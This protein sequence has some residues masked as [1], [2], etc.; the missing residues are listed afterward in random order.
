[1]LLLFTFSITSKRFLHDLVADHKDTIACHDN[2]TAHHIHSAGFYCTCDDL[3]AES[4]YMSGD[5][6]IELSVPAMFIEKQPAFVGN[7]HYVAALF[8][9]LRGPPAVI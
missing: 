1:M 2:L 5:N 9:E 3:V 8:S 4:V 6:T 7:Y